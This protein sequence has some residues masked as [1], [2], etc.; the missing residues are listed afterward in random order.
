MLLEQLLTT[1][2]NRVTGLRGQYTLK[3]QAGGALAGFGLAAEEVN[4]VPTSAFII[5]ATKFAIVDPA[6]YSGGL[7]NTP[8]TS[9]VPFGVDANGIYLNTNVYV[10]GNLRVDTNG[11]TLIQGLRGSLNIAVDGIVWSDNVARQA[12][13]QTLGNAGLA[14]NNNHLVI[15]DAVTIYRG[16]TFV[17]TR[18]WFGTAWIVPGAVINGN[19]LIDGSLAAQKIDTRGLTIKDGAGVVI[20]GAG[21]GLDAGLI[22]GLQEEIFQPA[23]FWEFD[24]SA[25]GWTAT[26]ATLTASM[27]RL[28]LAPTAPDSNIISPAISV[29][30]SEHSVVRAVINV[31]TLA[32][33]EGGLYWKIGAG[34]FN[35]TQLLAIPAPPGIGRHVVEWNLSA[36]TAWTGGTV[37]G[38]RLDIFA[39]VTPYTVESVAVGRY[40]S[41]G[42]KITPGNASTFIADA[43]I[44]NAQIGNLIAS[45]NFNGTVDA[46]GQITAAGTTG[47]AIAKTGRAVFSDA[48]LRGAIFYVDPT[49]GQD[50]QSVAL[51]TYAF[52][53][54]NFINNP[55]YRT[56]SLQPDGF[57]GQM[58]QT[59]YD[60]SKLII[61][62]G[63]DLVFFGPQAHA[64]GSKRNRVRAGPVL[65]VASASAVVD[66]F[67]SLWYRT[68]NGVTGLFSAWTPMAFVTEPQN[69][70]GSASLAFAVTVTLSATATAVEFTV[71]P[72]NANA[73]PLNPTSV[74]IRDLT[75]TVQG[76]NI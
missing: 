9:V 14:V 18:H 48:T 41:V 11:R 43:A 13:W 17:E 24:G 10:R 23:A 51:A 25:E 69:N 59:T 31:T 42:A 63:G 75:V 67:F 47:W 30:G 3:I 35:G 36:T 38:I 49:S 44:N 74:E 68:F 6:T 50:M 60:N 34:G 53:N 8:D 66:H 12:I 16:T 71:A 37:T 65:F 28:S 72:T 57:G 19:V 2:A 55:G 39:G 54:L 64:Q 4:G 52:A 15:G 61:S 21:V 73:V 76:Y 62:L 29:S 27:S 26:A 5:S 46:S 56:I 58:Q 45:N 20:F 22:N 40:G 33:W 1:T 32:G 7:T 70:Y